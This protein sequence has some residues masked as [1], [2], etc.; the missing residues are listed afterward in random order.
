[1]K[2]IHLPLFCCILLFLFACK[3]GGQKEQNAPCFNAKR[4]SEQNLY[5]FAEQLAIAINRGD[6]DFFNQRFLLNE[7]LENVTQVVNA[8]QEHR[9]G[10]VTGVKQSLNIGEQIVGSLGFDGYYKTP[11]H[12]QLSAAA[13]GIVPLRHRVMA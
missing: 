11:A 2:A 7:I 5:D 9:D 13:H 6:A 10:F 1:M 4:I 8:P 12:T 3:T